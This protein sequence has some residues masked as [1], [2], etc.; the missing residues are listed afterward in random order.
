MAYRLD[1]TYLAASLTGPSR[2]S[3]VPVGIASTVIAPWRF[4]APRALSVAVIV[5]IA[6]VTEFVSAIAPVSHRASIVGSQAVPRAVAAAASGAP[7]LAS[8]VIAVVRPVVASVGVA[9]LIH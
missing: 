4:A 5:G 8:V 9:L 1:R 3:R 2:R 7:V 6:R